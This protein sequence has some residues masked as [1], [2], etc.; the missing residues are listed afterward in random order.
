MTTRTT[1]RIALIAALYVVLTFVL[2][3]VSYGLLQFR[4]SEMLKVFVLLN[5]LYALGIGLG[6][7]IA[8]LFSPFAGP[9]DLLWMPLTDIAGGFLAWGLFRLIGRW[10]IF[11]SM[12][13]YALTTGLAVGMMLAAFGFGAWWLAAMPVIGSELIIMIVGAPILWRGFAWI[14]LR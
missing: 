3:P 2:A 8:N 9:W 6:T 14:N 4:V 11:P 12:V 1:V 13:L 10:S 7:L 5:P